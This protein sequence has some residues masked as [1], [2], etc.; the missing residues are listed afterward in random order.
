MFSFE[1]SNKAQGLLSN[2]M[3]VEGILRDQ[4][5]SHALD[6]VSGHVVHDQLS[7][8]EGGVTRRIL[9]PCD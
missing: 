7:Q 6:L 9:D 5:L 2:V 1:I 4:A 3:D 8:E